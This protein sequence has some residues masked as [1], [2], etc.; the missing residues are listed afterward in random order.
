MTRTHSQSRTRVKT[1]SESKSKPKPTHAKPLPSASLPKPTL[2]EVGTRFSTTA[3]TKLANVVLA[4]VAKQPAF[5]PYGFGAPWI[6]AM[7]AQ[8][9]AL[10][11]AHAD[12]RVARDAVVPTSQA[13][14]EAMHAAKEYRRRAATVVSLTP[15]ISHRFIATGSSTKK[16][17]ASIEDLLPRVASAATVPHGGGPALAKEGKDVLAALDAALG[18]H[19]SAAGEIS[20]ELRAL[21][22][23]K[24]IVY[25]ELQRLARAARFVVPKEASLY[26]PS[27]HLRTPTKSRK[28]KTTAKPADALPKPA[29]GTG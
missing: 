25:E 22:A 2:T 10:S 5:A 7:R 28:K 29:T 6:S 19:V 11:T 8:L 21:S 24:G 9:D 13:F 12:V 1:K 14:N 18:K 16:L 26:A 20:P 4:K 23:M 27:M 15:G 17:V 3:L